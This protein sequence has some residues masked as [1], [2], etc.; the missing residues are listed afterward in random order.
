MTTFF[1]FLGSAIFGLIFLATYKAYGATGFLV[2]VAVSFVY[3]VPSIIAHYRKPNNW[4]GVFALN[5]FFGW[6]FIGWAVAII[7]ACAGP[8]DRSVKKPT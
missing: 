4:L 7:W 1:N 3:L 2:A 5:I 8:S 6:S